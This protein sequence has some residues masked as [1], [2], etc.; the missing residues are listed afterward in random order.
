M[1]NSM[2]DASLMFFDA[3][4][5]YYWDLIPVTTVEEADLLNILWDEKELKQ[6]PVRHLQR[7][8]GRYDWMEETDPVPNDP[9]KLKE[10]IREKY[11]GL[12]PERKEMLEDL[13]RKAG[14]LPGGA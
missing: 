3:L 5:A 4:N 11:A 10:K 14:D 9:E 8:D 7:E 12:S 13:I 2:E 6:C 1:Q